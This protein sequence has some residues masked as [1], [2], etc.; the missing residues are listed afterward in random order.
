MRTDDSLLFF[1]HIVSPR[2]V[3][4][5]HVMYC[6]CPLYHI[7]GLVDEA[8]WCLALRLRQEA[9]ELPLWDLGF[10]VC[11]AFQQGVMGRRLLQTNTGNSSNS[12]TIQVR[13][14]VSHN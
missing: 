6:V 4:F 13:V 2:H 3:R 1:I 9:M 14:E 7:P 5:D 12:G 8:H 10:D 11:E